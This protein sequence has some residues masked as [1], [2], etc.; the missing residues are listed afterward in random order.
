MG[1]FLTVGT[2]QLNDYNIFEGN[3]LCVVWPCFFWCFFVL[4][5]LEKKFFSY[6]FLGGFE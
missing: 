5:V 3:V 4:I 2:I 1:R 6:Y